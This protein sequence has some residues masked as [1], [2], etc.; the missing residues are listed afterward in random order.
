MKKIGLILAGIF[1]ALFLATFFFAKDFDVRISEVSAQ[2][3]IDDSMTRDTLLS[4]GVKLD[5]KAATID[6][7]ANNTAVVNVEFKADGFGFSGEAKGNFGTGIDY[8]EPKFYLANIA[9]VDMT[10][11]LDADSQGKVDDVKNIAKDFLQR[12]RDKML[13]DEARKSLDNFVGRNEDKVKELAVAAT[14]KFFENLPIYDL[15]D[16]GLKGSI[17]ALALK[18]VTFT[19]T[20]AIVTLSP[21]RVIARVLSAVFMFLAIMLYLSGGTLLLLIPEFVRPRKDENT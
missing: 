16:A 18:K 19:E 14:Y 13:S 9:P 6:F 21:S 4:L 3:L 12:Q 1:G 5:I 15:N 10:L 20:D 8:R 7:K 17:A 2:K 11:N